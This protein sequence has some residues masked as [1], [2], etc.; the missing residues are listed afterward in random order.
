VRERALP[1]AN[2]GRSIEDVGRFP[3]RRRPLPRTA[4]TAGPWRWR[5]TDVTGVL[6]AIALVVP[7]PLVTGVFA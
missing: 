2:G 7:L 3:T 4:L 1:L 6:V 5:L